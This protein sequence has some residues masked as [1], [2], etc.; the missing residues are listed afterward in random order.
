MS[1]GPNTKLNIIE[2]IRIYLLGNIGAINTTTISASS[3]TATQNITAAGA[4]SIIQ[5]NAAGGGFKVKEGTNATMGV[6][7]LSGGAATVAT[8]KVTAN[9]RI[10]LSIQVLGTV[11][12]AKAIAVTARNAGQD[13]TITSADGTD[14]SDVAWLIIEPA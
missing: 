5:V 8:T 13:F 7:T 3:I 9:S 6:A 12:A 10:F 4:T 14:T 1:S 11:A 2:L